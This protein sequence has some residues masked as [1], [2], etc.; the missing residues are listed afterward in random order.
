MPHAAHAHLPLLHCL[1]QR[2][3][4]L[5]GRAIDL[6]G[7]HHIGKQWP[8]QK[9]YLPRA[10]G[11][12]LLEHIGADDVGRHEVGSELD[13]AEGEIQAAGERADQERFG[14]PRHPLQQAVAAAE[15]A[16]EQ[17]LHHLMLADNDP[18]ELFEN[19]VVGLV[20]TFHCRASE[21]R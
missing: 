11:P 14:Q 18:R 15:Q 20:E 1:Q 21:Y 17:F 8:L 16:D 10:G 2:C 4:R 9:A 3:L 13:A 6:V 5:G 12:V 7:E 19:P